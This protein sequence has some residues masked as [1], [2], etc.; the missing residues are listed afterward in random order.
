MTSHR[1]FWGRPGDIA[2]AVVCLCLNLKYIVSVSEEQASNFI[3]GRKTRLILH[4]RPP[5]SDK[6]PGPMD[7][8]NSAFIKLSGKHGVLPE[9][10]NALRETI[11]ARIWEVQMPTTNHQLGQNSGSPQTAPANKIKLRHHAGIGGI[12]K[13]IEEESK[14]TDENIALAFQDLRV[15]MAMAKDMVAISRSI[16]NNIRTKRGEIS[17]DE[18]VR[19]KS[20]L[21]SLGIDDPVTR[22]DYASESDYYNNLA[23][24]LGAMMLDPLEVQSLPQENKCIK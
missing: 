17:D 7:N 21:L 8:S 1:M 4:L 15:L 22:D 11:Q 13:A 9:F 5:A 18:T 16:S 10:A 12:E 24:Q 2:R 23:Q 20:Y 6:Q 3:F 14:A 19:F